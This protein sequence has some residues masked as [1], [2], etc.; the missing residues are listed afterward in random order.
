MKNDNEHA[1]PSKADVKHAVDG[2]D[3]QASR[4]SDAPKPAPN[5]TPN[6]GKT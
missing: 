4:P 1:H 2:K 5:P 3:A 6:N